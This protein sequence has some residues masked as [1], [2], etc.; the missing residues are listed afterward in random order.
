MPKRIDIV[1][2][3]L[4]QYVVMIIISLVMVFPF[5]WMVS[6]SLKSASELVSDSPVWFP[7]S[8]NFVS[9]LDIF[10]VIPFGSALMNSII[11]TGS[12]TLSI[13]ITSIMAGYV[14]AK[15]NFK[16]KNI[17]FL[18]VLITM[19]VPPAILIIPLYHMMAG[20]N[21]VNT[22]LGMILPFAA[23]GFGI[24]LMKQFIEGVPD[25]LLEASKIDG[26]SEWTILWR[27]V[28][29]QLK[30]ASSALI[31]FAYVF[32]WNNF[33]WPLVIVQSEDK[34]TVVLALNGLRSY[35]SSLDF[36]NIVMAGTIIGILPSLILFVFLQRFFVEGIS[37]TGIKG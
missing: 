35:T 13:L 3:K 4:M 36:E 31:I 7:S 8:P 25:D 15:H 29:P 18:C 1:F 11:M 10:D 9:F 21:L 2:K 34:N 17:I 22:Y 33:I 37:M 28:V 26:A 20:M 27:V 16:G 32:V 23:N 24:F 5:F 14:F 30:P 6:S 12:A 19:M